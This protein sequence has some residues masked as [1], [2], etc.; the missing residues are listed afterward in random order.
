M[1]IQVLNDCC[2]RSNSP[3]QYF[4]H[5]YIDPLI[6]QDFYWLILWLFVFCDNLLISDDF[7][8]PFCCPSNPLVQ[9]F[10]HLID[11]FNLTQL[12]MGPTHVHGHILDLILISGMPVP[13][14]QINKVS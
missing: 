3:F 11:S 4:V 10:L 1:N 9:G 8:I 5:V 13:N 6:Q 12:V 7:N 14:V 2:V